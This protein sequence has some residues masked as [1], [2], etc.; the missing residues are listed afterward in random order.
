MTKLLSLFY[1]VSVSFEDDERK[2]GEKTNLILKASPGS[3]V[4]FVAVDKSVQL[5]KA[6]NELTKEKVCTGFQ[7]CFAQFYHVAE[8]NQI[9]VLMLI[10]P[11][12]TEHFTPTP[13]ITMM[14]KANKLYCGC[15]TRSHIPNLQCS[16]ILLPSM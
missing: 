2:P 11:Y 9:A 14:T 6:G 3:R 12:Y 13:C 1:Q 10:W 5:L 8:N 15:R 7:M 16:V 4:A